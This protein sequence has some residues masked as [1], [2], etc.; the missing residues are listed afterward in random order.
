MPTKNQRYEDKASTKQ[1]TYLGRML[2]E[3]V[4]R[5]NEIRRY[6]AISKDTSQNLS[7]GL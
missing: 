1:I 3:E 7:K 5:N 6:I 4:K 2:T